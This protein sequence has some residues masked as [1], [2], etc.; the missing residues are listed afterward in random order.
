[1]TEQQPYLPGMEPQQNPI[2]KSAVMVIRE[3]ASTGEVFP[4]MDTLKKANLESGTFEVWRYG[5]QFTVE[6][7]PSRVRTRFHSAHTKPGAGKPK[8]RKAKKAKGGDNGGT[9]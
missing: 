4:D 9:A 7:V 1:M 2:P 3:G 6:E 8:A 5:G